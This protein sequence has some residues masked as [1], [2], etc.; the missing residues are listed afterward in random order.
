MSYPKEVLFWTQEVLSWDDVFQHFACRDSSMPIIGYNVERAQCYCAMHLCNQ[1]IPN[2]IAYII[3]ESPFQEWRCL[4]GC[5]IF[6]IYCTHASYRAHFS[7]LACYRR[8]VHIYYFFLQIVI[9]EEIRLLWK[10]ENSF[11]H[12]KSQPF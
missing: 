6:K 8:W 1:T 4:C 12:Q 11:L 10:D 3:Q 9:S 7:S 5:W 2:P